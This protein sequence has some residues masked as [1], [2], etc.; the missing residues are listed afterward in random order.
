MKA[1]IIKLLKE[2][3]EFRYAVAGMLG[4]RELLRRMDEN[5]G[6][7][8]SLQEQVAELQAEVREMQ[9]QVL[10]N[11][12]ATRG[13]QRQVAEHSEVIKSLQEQVAELQAEVR[14]LQKQVFEHSRAIRSLQEQVVELQAEV[15]ELQRQVAENTGAIRSLQEQVARHGQLIEGLQRELAKNTRA[16]T[17]L[18]ARWG[19]IAEEAFREGMRGVVEEILGGVVERWECF[20]E[21]GEVYSHPSRVEVDL[22]IRN[23]R[24]VLVE[25]KSSVSSGDVSELWRIGRLYER[26]TGIR[27]ELVIVSPYIDRRAREAARKMGVRVY[28]TLG[29]A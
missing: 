15:R 4:Y 18:G 23:G 20:D 14:E 9:K 7:I 11:V 19:L 25:V 13:L 5:T 1:K 2:D 29:E 26:K 8:R 27:P 21:A 28:T 16:L 6:A 10:E 17:A 12:E 24:H 3:E 22:V